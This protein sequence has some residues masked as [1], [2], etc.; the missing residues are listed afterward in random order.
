MFLKRRNQKLPIVVVIRFYLD[1]NS[2]WKNKEKL[3]KDKELFG[4][5]NNCKDYLDWIYYLHISKSQ[6]DFIM[7]NMYKKNPNGFKSYID[8]A[9]IIYSKHNTICSSIRTI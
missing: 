1:L 4:D 3:L 2:I 6:F 5:F 7:Q 9:T 8:L